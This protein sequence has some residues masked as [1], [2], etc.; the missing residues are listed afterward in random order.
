MFI[1]KELGLTLD[2]ALEMSDL[3]FRLWIA[4]F[5][6]EAKERERAMNRGRR[7]NSR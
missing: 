1:A 7:R 6:N 4:Y 5:R 2:K 3:E